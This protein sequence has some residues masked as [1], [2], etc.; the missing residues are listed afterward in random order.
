MFPRRTA[1]HHRIRFGIFGDAV[2]TTQRLEAACRSGGIC[3]SRELRDALA[4]ALE[5]AEFSLIPDLTVEAKGKGS[6]KV[7]YVERAAVPSA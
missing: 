5:K 7:W 4:G 3:V 2:N 6:L 1:G